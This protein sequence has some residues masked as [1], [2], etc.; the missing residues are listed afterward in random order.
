MIL[1]ILALVMILAS[2]IAFVV[3]PATTMLDAS[4]T[5]LIGDDIAAFAAAIT[6]QQATYGGSY[7]S[8]EDIKTVSGYEYLRLRDHRLVQFATAT[9]LNESGMHFDRFAIWFESPRDYVGNVDY[10][11]AAENSCSNG[12]FDT[13]PTWCGRNNSIWAK[14]E[15]RTHFSAQIL[16]EQQRMARTMAKFYRDYSAKQSFVPLA[17]A[18]TYSSLGQLVGYT[19]TAGNCAG[20]FALGEIILNCSDL[21]NHWGHPIYFEKIND[22]HI[23]LVNQTALIRYGS[24]V[25]LAEEARME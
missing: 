8:P 21:F 4:R 7:Q 19:G 25:R 18:G 1:V 24:N 5:Q 10:L 9:N 2:A 23:F 22:Q 11:S 17:P 15:S 3:A 6:E 16:G 14:A 13:D 20:E 12:D